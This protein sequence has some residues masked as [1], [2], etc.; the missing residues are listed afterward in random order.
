MHRHAS[1]VKALG[2]TTALGKVMGTKTAQVV[3]RWRRVGIPV[4]HWPKIAKMCA[5]RKVRIPQDIKDF[6]A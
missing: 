6:L 2:G 1:T 3:D 5:D 4:K